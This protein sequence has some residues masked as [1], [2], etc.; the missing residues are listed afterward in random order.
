MQATNE[1]SKSYLIL[2]A[3]RGEDQKG[4]KIR[5]A[6]GV[7]LIDRAA[8]GVGNSTVLQW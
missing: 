1:V 8:A 5:I 7:R 3:G 4:M 6:R 2:D